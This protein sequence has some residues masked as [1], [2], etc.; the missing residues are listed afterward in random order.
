MSAP[1]TRLRDRRGA[2]RLPSPEMILGTFRHCIP[3]R[4]HPHLPEH[5][6]GSLRPWNDVVRA[7]PCCW[8]G[9]PPE[10]PTVEH[11]VP[12]GC[13]GSE[14]WEN[15]VGACRRCNHE[16]GSLSVLDYL[17]QRA[18]LHR[19]KQRHVPLA[20]IWDLMRARAPRR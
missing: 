3:Y 16:R 2:I 19:L 1:P 7:D 9:A 12:R 5:L 20:T 10:D 18:F 13:G 14:S 6:T 4:H 17:A 15:K 11:V 8:C